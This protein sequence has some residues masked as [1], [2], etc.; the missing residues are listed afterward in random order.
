[1]CQLG[2]L[3]SCSAG[4]PWTLCQGGVSLHSAVRCWEWC[5]LSCS[6]ASE[7]LSL[8]SNHTPAPLH[9]RRVRSEESG[10]LTQMYMTMDSNISNTRLCSY[11]YLLALG[12]E[13]LNLF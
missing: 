4:D 7:L 12:E 9:Y 8:S 13:V 11:E 6:S 5:R 3:V 1:M 2:A 10:Y